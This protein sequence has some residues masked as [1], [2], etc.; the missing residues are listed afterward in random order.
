MVA[1]SLEILRQEAQEDGWGGFRAKQ[2]LRS[3]L[4]FRQQDFV[5]LMKREVSGWT[6]YVVRAESVCVPKGM[7]LRAVGME[8][9]LPERP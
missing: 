8:I 4:R 7:A 1:I 6:A 3:E 5:L 9:L 2:R